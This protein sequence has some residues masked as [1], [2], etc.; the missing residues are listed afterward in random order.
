MGSVGNIW[1]LSIHFSRRRREEGM[2]RISVFMSLGLSIFSW[3][4]FIALWIAQN[5]KHGH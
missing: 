3:M 1:L 4:G 5:I 2:N